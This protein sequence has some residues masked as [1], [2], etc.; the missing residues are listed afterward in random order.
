MT[1]DS[2]CMAAAKHSTQPSGGSGAR[3][4]ALAIVLSACGARQSKGPPPGAIDKART[5]IV[6]DG[7]RCPDVV[8]DTRP[9]VIVGSAGDWAAV[10]KVTAT[11]HSHDEEAACTWAEDGAASAARRLGGDAVVI[12]SRAPKEVGDLVECVVEAKVYLRGGG[13][14]LRRCAR[15]EIEGVTDPEEATDEEPQEE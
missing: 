4:L 13:E 9:V 3:W 7:E 2:G 8:G 12:L 11:R 1:I 15:E 5:V 14:F 6:S 10:G